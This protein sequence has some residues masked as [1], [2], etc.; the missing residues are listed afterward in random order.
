MRWKPCDDDDGDGDGDDD[1]DNG[2][3]DTGGFF[4]VFL[5]QLWFNHKGYHAVPTFLNAINNAIL[6]ANLPDSKGDP[7]AYGVWSWGGWGGGG[8]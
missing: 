3:G 2:G 6:R 8:G 5:V 4:L 1:D 7:A